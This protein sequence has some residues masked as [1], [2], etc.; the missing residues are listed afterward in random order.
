[1]NE[2]ISL[3]VCGSTVFA[4]VRQTEQGYECESSGATNQLSCPDAIYGHGYG[5]TKREAIADYVQ[6]ATRRM[7]VGAM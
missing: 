7:G 1:M 5:L 3:T 6:G 4:V 2:K